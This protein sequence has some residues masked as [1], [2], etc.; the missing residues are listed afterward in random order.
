MATKGYIETR[1]T[2]SDIA[3]VVIN[4]IINLTKSKPGWLRI[5]QLI[6]GTKEDRRRGLIPDFCCCSRAR[7]RATRNIRRS[8]SI[9]NIVKQRR[10]WLLQGFKPSVCSFDSVCALRIVGRSGPL[11]K[12]SI[13]RSSILQAS[14]RAS[15]WCRQRRWRRGCRP[16]RTTPYDGTFKLWFKEQEWRI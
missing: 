12:E 16:N 7:S 13:A 9:D 2:T 5:W 15:W 4:I 8:R 3:I 6:T 11:S 10:Q 14:W 1:K